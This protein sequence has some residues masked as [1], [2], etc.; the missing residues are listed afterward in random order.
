M[1]DQ[2][3]YMTIVNENGS[4]ELLE[5]VFTFTLEQYS[6]DYVVCSKEVTEEDGQDVTELYLFSY[7]EQNDDEGELTPVTDETELK[8][9]NEVIDSFYSEA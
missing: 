3:E 8:Y 4:E 7:T 2:R 9:C 1:E 5:I 6:K